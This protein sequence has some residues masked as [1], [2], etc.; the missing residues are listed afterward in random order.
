MGSSISLG[1]L[2]SGMDTETMVTKI[3]DVERVRVLREESRAA[4]LAA[5]QNAWKEVKG[6]LQ[7]LR[8]SLDG[9]RL[10]STFTARRATS[11]D[12]SAATV[13]AAAGATVTT[14]S[15]AVTQLAQ[16]HVVATATKADGNTALFAAPTSGSIKIDVNGKATTLAL[17]Q[18]DT[19]TTL[20]DKINAAAGAGVTAEI[21]KVT[22]GSRIVLTSKDSG[23]AGEIR[24]TAESGPPTLLTDLGLHKNG[25]GVYV[26]QVVARQDAIFTLDGQD[27]TRSSNVVTDTVPGLTITLKKG[28]TKDGA[29]VVTPLSATV[30]VSQDQDAVVNAVTKWAGSLNATLSLLQ[31][32][33]QYNASSKAAGALN[34]DALARRLQSTLRSMLSAEVTGLPGT[35]N[36]LSQLGITTG[37]YGADDYGKVKVDTEKLKA[38]LTKDPVA[39]GRLFGAISTGTAAAAGVFSGVGSDMYRFVNDTLQSTTGAIDTRD[40]LLGDQIK[41]IGKR[42]ESINTRLVKREEQLRAQFLRM[43][44]TMSQLQAQGNAIL[45]LIT[46]QNDQ[47]K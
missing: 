16:T 38:E 41:E 37:A 42:V 3:M 8:S 14:H 35:M 19:L 32:K 25:D 46:N 11:S 44:Q 4:G 18:A 17:T 29:G 43:E 34:G 24:V 12:E 1:G 2:I 26:N 33:T 36:R 30:T 28:G 45:S 13:S 47:R 15:L 7:S 21:V 40:T 6:S 5:V 23:V 27:Y 39:V 20:R 9:I 10:S 31:E 22:G